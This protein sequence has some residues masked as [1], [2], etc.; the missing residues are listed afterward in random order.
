MHA[1]DDPRRAHTAGIVVGLAGVVVVTWLI[2]LSRGQVEVLS[3]AILYQL[4]VLAVSG[5]YGA[6]A[7]LTTGL[8]SAAAFN[9]F[10]IP[11]TQTLSVSDTRNWVSLV[12]FA[13]TAIATSYLAD[14]FRRQRRESEARRRDAEVL[15]DLAETALAQVGPGHPGPQVEAAAARAL[16][17]SWCRLELAPAA[18]GDH[19]VAGHLRPSPHGFTVPLVAG[20]RA[21]GLL[22]VG[23]ASPG[24]EPRWATPGFALA[25]GALAAVAVERGRIVEAALETESLRRSDELK[26]ALLH[27]VSH[28]F[29]T[30]L[31]AIRTAA[32]TLAEDP[33]GP[34]AREL[35]AAM[36]TETGRLE[37]LVANLLDLSRLEAGALVTRLDWC[38][39]DEI[40]AGALDAAEPFLAGTPV[41]VRIDP[42]LPLVRADPVLSERILVNLLH[43]AVRH[44]RPPVAIAARRA[45]DRLELRV[46]DAGPGPDPAV[47]GRLFDPF[48]AGPGT[49]GTGV[50]LALARGLAEA[51]GAL[52]EHEVEGSGTTFVLALALEPVP[53]VAG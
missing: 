17:V 21:L 35:L 10:F 19:N 28:E 11:P 14:G 5:V 25:V 46:T 44:G 50:G 39:P 23:P 53:A 7:G 13:A 4:L 41:S 15:T 12:V 45:G 27:G 1:L 9:W 52:L 20:G 31:T 32:H 18:V 42:D 36:S 48:A 26:T 29:R 51:Q 49:G 16:G 22:E 2:H 34:A 43:N 33:E 8:V 6:V 40:V 3:M 37:R 47:A 24:E 38:A 30:P